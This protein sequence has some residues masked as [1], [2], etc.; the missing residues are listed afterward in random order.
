MARGQ[1]GT[2]AKSAAGAG[3]KQLAAASGAPCC[4]AAVHN[5]TRLVKPLKYQSNCGNLSG[6]TLKNILNYLIFIYFFE[7]PRLA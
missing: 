6:L 1:A 4:A 2:I 3:R 5:K 7:H